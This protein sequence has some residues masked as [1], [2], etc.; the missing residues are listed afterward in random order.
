MI[1]PQLLL[2]GHIIVMIPFVIVLIFFSGNQL[3][4]GLVHRCQWIKELIWLL[5]V[6][7]FWL[8]DWSWHLLLLFFH[9]LFFNTSI[10][11]RCSFTVIFIFFIFMFFA[12]VSCTIISFTWI[13]I[14]LMCLLISTTNIVFLFFKWWR[15]F[16]HYS[17]IHHIYY[18]LFPF[19]LGFLV[20]E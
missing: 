5:W 11:F 18:P 16:L 15:C 6:R 3:L 9:N 4:S 13:I 2:H 19:Y 1:I 8:K 17:S 7:N 20:L 12:Q 10:Y 14:R